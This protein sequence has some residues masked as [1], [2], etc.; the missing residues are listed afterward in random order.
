MRERIQ[1]A[2]NKLLEDDPYNAHLL[3]Q[4]QSFVQCKYFNNRQSFAEI[5]SVNIFIRSMLQEIFVLPMRVS[6]KFS[7][8]R[9]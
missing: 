4:R 5:L 7:D 6:L 1:A 9:H 3:A 8:K 2:V